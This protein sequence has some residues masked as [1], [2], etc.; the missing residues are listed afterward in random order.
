MEL[1]IRPVLLDQ[2]AVHDPS[3]PNVREMTIGITSE[4][5]RE[6][7]CPGYITQAGELDDRAPIR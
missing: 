7:A 2:G 4:V 1:P 6:R 5:G 3:S